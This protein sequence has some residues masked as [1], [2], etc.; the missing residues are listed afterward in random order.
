MRRRSTIRRIKRELRTAWNGDDRQVKFNLR[1]DWSHTIHSGGPVS[2][3][4]QDV[5][6]IRQS[7][8]GENG[9]KRVFV[10]S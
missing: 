1:S 2:T 4:C 10:Y 5:G 3:C 7:E 6:E 9:F 8:V